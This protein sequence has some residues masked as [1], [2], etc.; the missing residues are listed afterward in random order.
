MR[1]EVRLLAITINCGNDDSRYQD[2]V[3]YILKAREWFGGMILSV[4]YGSLLRWYDSG[5]DLCSGR[6][7]RVVW[8]FLMSSVERQRAAGTIFGTGGSTEPS[9][10]LG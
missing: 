1:S 7:V 3:M 2:W 6:S 5:M 8:E 10:E 9:A 4:E